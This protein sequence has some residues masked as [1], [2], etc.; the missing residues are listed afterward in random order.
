MKTVLLFSMAVFAAIVRAESPA[1]AKAA[2][3]QQSRMARLAEAMVEKLPR[4]KL[5]EA[6]GFF[7]P[8]VKRYNPVIDAFQREYY[9]AEDKKAVIIKYAPYCRRA[10][11]EAKAMKVPPRYEA[12]KQG[13][14]KLANA[15]VTGLELLI[16]F[17]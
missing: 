14:L 6:T 8:I 5:R 4:D 9:R 3:P 17:N 1:P 13:Y 15:F 2:P 10:Y 12:E 11:E 7:A 16:R